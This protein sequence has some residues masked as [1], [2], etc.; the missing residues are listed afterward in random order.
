MK[1]ITIL[2][3]VLILII[4]LSISVY[5]LESQEIEVTN[6]GGGGTSECTNNLGCTNPEKAKC[7]SSICVGCT[8]NLDDTQ[9]GKFDDLNREFCKVSSGRCVECLTTLDCTG[10]D[11]CYQDS[12]ICDLC[13]KNNDCPTGKTCNNFRK[14]VD[15][16]VISCLDDTPC[17]PLG[18]K[19]IGEICQAEPPIAPTQEGIPEEQPF[20]VFNFYNIIISILTLFGYY[21]RKIYK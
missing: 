9:C 8:A 13:R 2:T 10:D 15:V 6:S 20:P 11:V 7:Q 4:L 12:N 21:I 3:I 18:L 5:A 1:T 14:C 19:C 17:I 16:T